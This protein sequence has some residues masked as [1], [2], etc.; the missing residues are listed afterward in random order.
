MT[1]D[2]KTYRKSLANNVWTD[3]IEIESTEGAQK[4]VDAHANQTDIHVT[5]SDKDKWNG[6]QLSKITADHGGVSITAYE[7]EDILQKIV[8]QGRTMG[9]FYAHG[10]AV[11]APSTFSTRGIFHITALSSDGKGVYGWA[12]AT[13]YKNNVFTN[14]YDGNTTYWKGWERLI[15]SADFESVTWQNVALKNGASNGERIFQYAKWGRLLLLRGHIATNREI[16]CGSLPAGFYPSSGATI[17]VTVSGTAGISKLVISTD[18]SLKI[19]DILSKD[20]S[21][22]TGYY[23]DKVIPLD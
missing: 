23:M 2:N 10:K 15:P 4:K 5:K 21:L 12:Y 3:W 1:N 14:Y 13:D 20:D 17:D 7:G 9:T 8:D 11:N 22:V 19:T 16:I 6:A 18:G